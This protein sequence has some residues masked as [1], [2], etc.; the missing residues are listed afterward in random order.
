MVVC[1]QPY[2][3]IQRL[4]LPIVLRLTKTFEKWLSAFTKPSQSNAK[5]KYTPNMAHPPGAK[6]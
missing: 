4:P 3:E 5:N 6:S 1:H 2:T